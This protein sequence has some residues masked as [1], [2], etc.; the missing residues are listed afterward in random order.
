MEDRYPFLAIKDALVDI[1]ALA[2]DHA[3]LLDDLSADPRTPEEYAAN[4][5]PWP[6]PPP[7]YAEA[8][9][10]LWAL[11]AEATAIRYLLVQEI[12]RDHEYY[13]LEEREPI[14]PGDYRHYYE[15]QT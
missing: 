2:G 12:A 7:I 3:Q 8:S 11:Q 9:A 4:P 15:A 14:A 10:R 13:N 6:D 5:R 1:A